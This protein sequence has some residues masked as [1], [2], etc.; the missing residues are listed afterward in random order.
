[1]TQADIESAL[2]RAVE[3][4]QAASGR[5]ATGLGSS[6]KPVGSLDGFDSLNG[7]EAAVLVEAVL[8]CTV[9]ENPLMDDYGRPVTIAHAAAKIL[10]VNRE[11]TSD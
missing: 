7:I 8:G 9:P 5:T 3:E 6:T 2:V 10:A 11:T 4:I 1:M